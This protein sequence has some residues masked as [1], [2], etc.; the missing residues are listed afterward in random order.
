MSLTANPLSNVTSAG[1]PSVMSSMKSFQNF[2]NINPTQGT[3]FS[4]AFASNYVIYNAT[5]K[6]YVDALL[7]NHGVPNPGITAII[8]ELGEHT[9]WATKTPVPTSGLPPGNVFFTQLFSDGNELLSSG[10]LAF[11]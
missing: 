5:N 1:H 9:A 6:A 4:Q 10:D 2:T 8:V 11:P 3:T 7:T